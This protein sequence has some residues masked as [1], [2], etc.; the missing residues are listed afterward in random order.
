MSTFNQSVYRQCTIVQSLHRSKP[1]AARM[2]HVTR[3]GSREYMQQACIH[4][5]KWCISTT[6]CHSDRVVVLSPCQSVIMLS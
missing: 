1:A 2:H 6:T 4:A 5:S 3:P